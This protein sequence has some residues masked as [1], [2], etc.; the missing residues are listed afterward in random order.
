MPADR[1]SGL[2]DREKARLKAAGTPD[3]V[4]PMLATLTGKAFS[5]PAW[6]FERKLDGIRCLAF[7]HGSGVRLLSRNKQDLA[8]TYPEVADAIAL[9]PADDFVVDGEIVA[10]EGD[11]TSFS[12]LQQRSGITDPA[13]ARKSPVKVS[14]YVFDVMHLDGFDTRALALRARKELL[15]KTLVTRPPLELIDH[16]DADGESFFDSACANGW[17]GLIAKRADSSYVAKRS[18][19]WLKLKCARGQEFVV[20]GFTDPT[21]S[22]TAF[23]ALLLGYYDGDRF[24]YAGK[25]GTGFDEKMLKDLMGRMKPLVADRP[26]FAGSRRFERGTHFVRPEIVVEVGFSEWTRDGLLRQ[27]RFLGLRL[28]KAPQ[29]VTREEARSG[30]VSS[31]REVR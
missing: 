25:V 31:Q 18:A 13:R 6:I 26:P 2:P 4:D 3:W 19:Y 20:G 28:D 11:R 21:G 22:R 1:F 10:F 29:E 5:D 23:G 27:P 17:E 30:S 9:Q 16:R 14:Y 7:R 15:E 24:L 12:L 8:R